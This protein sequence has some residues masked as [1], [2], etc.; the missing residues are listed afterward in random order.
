MH[1]LPF[2]LGIEPRTIL[3]QIYF[4]LLRARLLHT[5]TRP[6]CTGKADPFLLMPLPPKNDNKKKDQERHAR[7]E[8]SLR[9]DAIRAGNRTQ[10][11]FQREKQ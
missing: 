3:L 8:L 6:V 1:K 11:L 5:G 2:A 7:F 4:L 9:H 10:D